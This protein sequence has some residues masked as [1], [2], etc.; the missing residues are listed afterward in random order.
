MRSH[1]FEHE[2]DVLAFDARLRND[3]T[4]ATA[5]PSKMLLKVVLCAYAHSIVSS[6]GR[7]GP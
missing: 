5:Y 4:G 7:Y 3:A 2:I 6:R 1:L